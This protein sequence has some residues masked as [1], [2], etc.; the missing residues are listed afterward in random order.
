MKKQSPHLQFYGLVLLLTAAGWGWLLLS[1]HLPGMQES[2]GTV[3]LIKKVSGIPCPSCGSTRSLQHLFAGHI[4]E[5][6]ATNPLGLILAVLLI[7]VP[8]WIGKDLLAK[9]DSFYR[10]YKKT[11]QGIRQ[12]KIAIPLILLVTANWIWNIFKGL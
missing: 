7:V 5:A 12:R 10:A 6:I 3:C 1:Q 9:S 2:T 4:P 8:A 11:E